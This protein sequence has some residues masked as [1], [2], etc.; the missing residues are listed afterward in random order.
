MKIE[1]PRHRVINENAIKFLIG[2]S[3][4]ALPA[5]EL[6][7]ATGRS[8]PFESLSAS[9]AFNPWA[10][11]VFV[12]M[13]FAIGAFMA[14]YNGCR[15]SEGW[16]AKIGAAAAFVVALVPGQ[17]DGGRY[18][19]QGLPKQV[20]VVA[21]VVLFIVLIGFCVSFAVNAW[22]KLSDPRRHAAMGRLVVYALCVA[23]MLTAF[24]LFLSAWKALP[25]KSPYLLWGEVIGLLSFGLAWLTSSKFLFATGHERLKPLAFRYRPDGKLDSIDI[26][27]S[28]E[29]DGIKPPPASQA[30]RPAQAPA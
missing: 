1:K 19:I 29:M 25:A 13:L 2:A 12:G 10:R 11:D 18:L 5:I 14:T 15:P 27:T 30:P 7:L 8:D 16:L 3:A 23:G 28:D 4:F 9:Y 26:L 17:Y 21:T 20:H 22:R 6:W 24:G